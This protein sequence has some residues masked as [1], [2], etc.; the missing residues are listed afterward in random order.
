MGRFAATGLTYNAIDEAQQQL[1]ELN[2]STAMDSLFA[3][4]GRD[5]VIEVARA[6]PEP[7]TFMQRMKAGF[8]TDPL[9]EAQ[10]YQAE[11]I[12][13]SVTPD[14]KTVTYKTPQG[15]AL[16]DPE[17][18]DFPGD[19]AD[20]V[21]EGP[22]TILAILGGFLGGGPIA[23]PGFAAAGGMAGDVARQKI[24]Q[25][26]GSKRDYD[27]GQT[28][29]EGV[30]SVTG[31]V[32]GAGVSKA[33]KGPLR[34]GTQAPGFQQLSDDLKRFDIDHDT[35]LAGTAPVEGTV[36]GDALPAFAQRLRE[37]DQWGGVIRDHDVLFREEISS[38]MDK[39]G[40]WLPGEGPT[41][42]RRSREE[43]GNLLRDAV[44]ATQQQRRGTRSGLYEGFEEVIDPNVLPDM[45]NT[46]NTIGEIMNHNTMKRQKSG[47]TGR[48]ALENALEEAAGI[49]NY[50]TLQVVR[51]GIFDEANMAKSDPTKMSSGVQSQFEKLYAALKA[52][53]N[54]FLE[55]GGGTGSEVARQ[56]GGE[57]MRYAAEMFSADESR[58]VRKVLFN[59][60]KVTNI[61][62][63]V[64]NAT[65]EEIK[66]L[67]TIVGMGSTDIMQEGAQEGVLEATKEGAEAWAALQLEVFKDL[68]QASHTTP[69][70]LRQRMVGPERG[71]PE[72]ISG[73]KLMN[74]LDAF[75]EGSLEEIFGP[76]VT[77]DLKEFASIVRDA[78]ITESALANFSGTAR[79]SGSLFNDL[80]EIFWVGQPGGNA[81]AAMARIL[82]R[83][84]SGW[85]GTRALTT[86]VGKRLLRGEGRFQNLAPATALET[87]GRLGG[88]TGAREYGRDPLFYP[89]R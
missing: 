15:Q 63:M 35:N 39:I 5:K 46:R 40:Q 82:S 55:A 72:L 8:A 16:A 10:I 23:G 33:L 27:P 70:Q 53:E 71:G 41:A 65:P 36:S 3:T 13:A 69:G 18:F 21:G 49:D 42:A 25:R 86:P 22:A 43:T 79:A 74:A 28:A 30:T 73:K 80:K 89:G 29:I 1:N 52:D 6:G 59:E 47:T 64:R 14:G 19:F 34:E 20:A 9:S 62:D 11:G 26:F 81:N 17:G 77:R 37:D 45:S 60:E 44:T 67:R 12:P 83:S 66:A 76:A 87:L 2:D 57:A 24:A 75:K 50:T 78:T 88:Q 84:L 48:A 32:L 56:R 51:Q 58:F 7:P 31:D 85:L 38:A 68:R 54:A 61:P 4:Y